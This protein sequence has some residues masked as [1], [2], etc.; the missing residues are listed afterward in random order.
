[1]RSGQFDDQRSTRKASNT[2]L[3]P[4]IQFTTVSSFRLVWLDH[5]DNA[6][7][8]LGIWRPILT[9]GAMFLGD[10]GQGN[11]GNPMQTVYLISDILN[12]DP[13]SPALLPPIG[14]SLLW[15]YG[16]SRI[17]FPIE[18]HP[19][20]LVNAVWTLVAPRNYVPCGSIGTS[21]TLDQNMNPIPPNFIPGLV[22]VCQ[23]LAKNIPSS[24]AQFVWNDGRDGNPLNLSIRQIP[25]LNTMIANN[26]ADLYAPPNAT[27]VPSNSPG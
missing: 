10:H 19:G 27:F 21:T 23:D 4:V 26:V 18:K 13:N 11:L 17:G 22:C 24:Q 9:S 8:E 5:G 20:D 6:R 12:D 16:T 1:M 14:F 15:W 2:G 7:L 25:G 3:P